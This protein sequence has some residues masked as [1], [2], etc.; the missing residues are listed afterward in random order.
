LQAVQDFAAEA[1][2]Q[3]VVVSAQVEA[4]FGV[5]SP[6]LSWW[7]KL[8]RGRDWKWLGCA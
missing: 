3:V 6:G 2:D 5:K 8:L 4:C 7:L 1:G